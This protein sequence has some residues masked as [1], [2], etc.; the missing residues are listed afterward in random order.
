[1]SQPSGAPVV[2]VV[3]RPNVGKSTLV[4]RLAGGREAI[5]EER[6]G[7]TRDRTVH[8]AE[9]RG[10]RLAVVDSGGWTPGWGEAS[11]P[12]A[13]AVTAQAEL[14]AET[15]DLVLFVMD[16]SV[17][18]TEE[19]A[20]VA[21]WL[22][23]GQA[24]VLL[25]ANKADAAGAGRGMLQA[26]L[27][28][29]HGLGLGEPEPLSALHGTGSGDLLDRVIDALEDRGAFGRTDPE[30]AGIPGVALLGRPNVGKSSLFNQLVGSE[31]AIVDERPGTTR[32][33]VDT[34]VTLTD[35]RRYRFVDT[36]GMRRRA[37]VRRGGDATEYFSTVRTVKAL[38]AAAVVLLV[39][40]AADVIGEQ[41]Q[42]L[43]RQVLDAGRGV[44][45][46]LNKWDLVDDE[47]RRLR[48]RELERLLHFLPDA[49]LLRTSATT[50]R[51]VAKLADRIDAV[52]T[53]W[54]RRVS[55]SRLNDW[56]SEAVAASPP[57]LAA[58]GRSIRLRYATQV[59]VAPPTVR[60]FATGP[61]EDSY[62][63]YLERSMREAFGFAGTPIDI[64]VR[65]RPRWEERQ[66]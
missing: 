24:P 48:E 33:A 9:W 32:D 55:T 42:R 44:V 23:R 1:M 38:E 3:G 28:E 27:A 19:D 40:D 41:E 47:D 6:P 15:A 49:P 8:D 37:R 21:G 34:V 63:R 58:G 25:V 56:L 39:V 5:V 31:R 14:A 46:V 59:A 22:R 62:V 30:E 65:V 10:R 7:V 29:L 54:R 35:G 13:A 11:D 53:E 61:V 17:G 52:L 66:R 64:A 45:L 20:A 51:G 57:P 18:V 4:N 50:G 12:L 36:A 26:A 43:A 16:V 2:A 60:V